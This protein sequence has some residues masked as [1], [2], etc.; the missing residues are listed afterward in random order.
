MSSNDDDGEKSLLLFHVDE[1]IAKKILICDIQALI[2]Q[3]NFS[4]FIQHNFLGMSN[5]I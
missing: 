2:H 3:T 1:N 5:R 4:D